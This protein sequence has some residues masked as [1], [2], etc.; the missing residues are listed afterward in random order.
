MIVGAFGV[1]TLAL[2]VTGIYGVM[3]AVVGERTREY[4]VRLALGATTRRVNRHVLRQA[5]L[6]IVGVITGGLVLAV[7]ASRYVASL[8]YGVVPLDLPSFGVAAAIVLISSIAAALIPA[9]RAARVDPMIALR[10]E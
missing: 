4:G 9:R 5:S 10:A 3:S 8:L 6:P 2:A 7:W 1:L